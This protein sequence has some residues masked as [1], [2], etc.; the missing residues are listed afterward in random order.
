M[1]AIL[2]I[3]QSHLSFRINGFGKWTA[4]QM[5]VDKVKCIDKTISKSVRNITE[6]LFLKK[7]NFSN[8]VNFFVI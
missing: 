1:H 7:H 4:E 6:R 8:G 5:H 3:E 2:S